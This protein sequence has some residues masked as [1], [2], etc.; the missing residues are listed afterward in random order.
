MMPETKLK[1]ISPGQMYFYYLCA[2]QR[3]TNST[4]ESRDHDF[5]TEGTQCN[6]MGLNGSN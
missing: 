2:V 4:K 1:T 6:I 5:T 3:T